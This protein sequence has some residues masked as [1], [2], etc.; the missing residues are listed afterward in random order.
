MEQ[1]LLLHIYLFVM[2]N[3]CCLVSGY[4]KVDDQT[5]RKQSVF[6]PK[7]LERIKM[8]T[9]GGF[10]CVHLKYQADCFQN[11]QLYLDKLFSQHLQ[12]ILLS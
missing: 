8:D 5:K 11:F 1:P 6:C 7:G 3:L 10:I 12:E 4:L 9:D 2:G